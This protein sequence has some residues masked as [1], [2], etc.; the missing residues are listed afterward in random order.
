MHLGKSAKS[1]ISAVMRRAELGDPRMVRRAVAL[2]EALA[3][4]PNESLPKIW[5]TPAELEA[6]YRFLRNPRTEFEALVGAFQ[7]V[8]RER[9]LEARRILAIHDT[10][11][12]ECPAADPDEVGYLQTG[13]PGFYVH[14]TLVVGCNDVISPLGIIWSQLWG[15][16]QR[17]T[18][19]GPNL[20]GSALAKMKERESDR[21]LEGVSETTA[22]AQG[23]EQVIHVMDREADNYRLYEHLRQL[24]ADFIIRMRHDRRIDDGVLTEA[25]YDAPVKFTRVVPLSRRRAKTMPSYTHQGRD[26]REASLVVRS[27]TIS[28]LPPNYMGDSESIELNVV[29]VLEEDPP[30]GEEP[31]AWVLATSLPVKTPAQVATILD[32]YRARWLIEEFHKALKTGCLVEKRQLESFESITTLLALCYPIACE[33]LRLRSHARQTHV[34]ASAVMRP[35]LLKCLRQHPKARPLSKEPSMEEAL[36]VIAG[37]GGHIKH[38]GPPGWQTIAAGYMTIQEFERGWLAAT[39]AQNL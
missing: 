11:D 15:R 30:E 14:H 32:F 29:Q 25:L 27:A 23:C 22:W 34:L 35:S 26:A 4:A 18:K 12:C 7:Q 8:T 13:K 3:E 10:T 17:T 6:A 2:A 37:L 19:R 31:I 20:P 21:W 38:N 1:R 16:A 36:A 39:A 24:G 9:A 33:I 5:A 28:I